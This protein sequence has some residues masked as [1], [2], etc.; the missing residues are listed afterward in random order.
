EGT[1]GSQMN[2]AEEQQPQEDVQPE[3]KAMEEDKRQQAVLR[4]DEKGLKRLRSGP[5]AG[6]ATQVPSKR[7]KAVAGA[8]NN[9]K[10]K[11]EKIEMEKLETEN[12]L[13]AAADNSAGELPGAALPVRPEGRGTAVS[14]EGDKM[15]GTNVDKKEV[16][17]E[18]ASEEDVLMDD[19]EEGSAEGAG[20][21][22]AVTHGSAGGEDG[23]AA[24]AA[25]RE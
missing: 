5:A 15:G 11:T 25:T 10:P 21:G 24:V 13:T 18:K 4:A 16:V 12:L 9:E 17:V 8:E 19:S 2:L 20:E 7:Q 6:E 1:K 14:S 3:P 22:D 23:A